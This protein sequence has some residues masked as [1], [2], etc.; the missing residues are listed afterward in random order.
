MEKKNREIVKKFP[1]EI[2]RNEQVIPPT[3]SIEKK[4]NK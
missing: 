4:L 3:L 1:S 2:E